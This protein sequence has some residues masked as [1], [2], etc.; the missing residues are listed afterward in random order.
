MMKKQQVSDLRAQ[1]LPTPRLDVVYREG[2]ETHSGAVAPHPRDV[3]EYQLRVALTWMSRGRGV[4]PCS[5]T[6]KGPMVGGFARNATPEQLAKFYDAGQVREWW[7]G[8]FRRAHVGLLT[9]DGLVVDLDMPK[10]GEGPLTG[11][12]DGCWNGS[13]VLERLAAEAGASFPETYTVLTPSGGMHLHLLQPADG[14]R[15]GCATGENGAC[16]L[17][18]RVDVRGDGGIIIAPGSYSAAQGRPYMRVS[19]PELQAQPIPAWLLKLLRP[20]AKPTSVPHRPVTVLPTGTDA[21]RLERAA[22]GA[23]RSAA[24]KLAALRVGDDRRDR[25]FAYARW[26][27]EISHTAPL[28]LTETTVRDVLLPAAL[29]CGVS[30]HQAEKSI[31]NGW[32]HGVAAPQ[33]TLQ[34]GGAA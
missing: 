30:E 27:G 18:P 23:L 33:T 7:T 20:A 5:R 15:I 19:A 13:D 32:A 29:A 34:L 3:A 10:P 11:R 14:P 24:E 12:W 6:D 22:Q 31:R 2:E 1:E 28:V 4:V 17:G 9:R 8:R 25:T 21:T 26:L 16:A